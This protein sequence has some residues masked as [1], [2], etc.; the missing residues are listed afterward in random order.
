MSLVH[1]I[2]KVKLITPSYL[3]HTTLMKSNGKTRS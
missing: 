3:E 2:P 1:P